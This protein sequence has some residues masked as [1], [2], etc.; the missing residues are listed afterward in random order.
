MQINLYEYIKTK[1]KYNIL[2]YS[3]GGTGKT[4]QMI[5]AFQQI[6][7]S[8]E[9][10]NKIPL[11][12]DVKLLDFNSQTPILKFLSEIYLGKQEH[13]E[14]LDLI[15]SE[16][17]GL[18]DLNGK[19][20]IFFID[21][22]NETT[23]KINIL[24]DINKLKQYPACS[25][26]VSSRVDEDSFVFEDFTR[27]KLKKIKHSNIVRILNEEYNFSKILSADVFDD[28]L[29]E[30]LEYPLFLK[31]FCMAYDK[32]EIM[33][34]INNKKSVRK[35]DIITAY[36]NKI[37][38]DIKR[39]KTV[40]E[41]EQIE[42]STRFFL[43]RLAFLLVG[44]EKFVFTHQELKMLLSD[45]T[46]D[47]ISAKYFMC[48]LNGKESR[49]FIS[50]Y[51][52]NEYDVVEHCLN[53]SLLKYNEHTDSYEFLHHIW[54]DYFASWHIVNLING[55]QFHELLNMP[56]EIMIRSFVGEMYKKNGKCEYDYAK[57][58]T[59]FSEK[60]PIESYMQTHCAELNRYPKV[61]AN[62][63]DIMKISRDNRITAIYDNL[64]LQHVTFVGC[65]L[66]NSSFNNS[67]IYEENFYAQGH[68]GY[69][70]DATIAPGNQKIISCG[71]DSTIR[72]WDTTMQKQIGDPLRGH[73]NY[74]VSVKTIKDGREIISGSYDGT[75]RRWN[76]ETHK[77]I[78]DPLLGHEKRINQIA[79]TAD[80]KYIV[81]CS[82][83][84]TIRIWSLCNG[85]QEGEALYGHNGVVNSIC[86]LPGDRYIISAG[87]DGTVRL[88]D[89][90]THKQSGTSLFGHNCSVKSVCATSDGK[91]VISAD[92]K[93]KV[94]IW[95]VDSRKRLGNALECSMDSVESIAISPDDSNILA[96]GYDGKIR[97]FDIKQR[98]LIGQIDAHGD[99]INGIS[100]SNDGKYI[101][102]AGGDQAV[103]LWDKNTLSLVGK[104]YI[105]TDSWINSV[106]ITSDS[107]FII[108]A[109]DD[110]A[111]RIWDVSRKRM[112]CEPRYGHTARI[113]ELDVS[114]KGIIVSASD[115]G[116]VGVWNIDDES[117]SA[118]LH[119]HTSWVRT[120]LLF[121]NEKFAIS[122]GWDKKIIIWDLT[123]RRI[124]KELTGHNASVEALALTSNDEFLISGSD[125][126]TIRFWNVK[127][128]TESEEPIVAHDDWIR[129][130]KLTGNE[131]AIITGS[132]DNTIRIWDAK[133]H[134]MLGEN[135]KG[136]SNRIDALA[137]SKDNIIISGSDDNTVRAWIKND[138]LYTGKIIAN[139]NNA[140]SSVSIS[141]DSKYVASGDGS[142]IIK[143]TYLDK[144]KRND[145]I[146]Q[147]R[148]NIFN[149]DLTNVSDASVTSKE[150]LH[151]LY[152]NGC[153]I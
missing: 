135:L 60:S 39:R 118:F 62:L 63:I 90:I 82:S 149:S 147:L 34:F 13:Y 102:S 5:Y 87:E 140:V 21:G 136:H 25:L 100:F 4:T 83:D 29:L 146:Q 76:A 77:Q 111:I 10:N 56:S 40:D 42:F 46:P 134:N 68:S 127:N 55:N 65:Q 66:P 106:K 128:G 86:V 28:N 70:Y 152:Q 148:L 80:E 144:E 81:S 67:K 91:Y 94:F 98:T 73:T 7:D 120:V 61:V 71:K 115:D 110:A 59:C 96:A 113:N 141:N 22:L 114:E 104:P 79:I 53:L 131:N 121:G 99:W 84:E 123:N 108:S 33:D 36:I 88:W 151:V 16:K 35:T 58:T 112:V 9:I 12:I 64:D 124:M 1:G 78:G 32:A 109:G 93:G 38:Q 74:V 51:I 14:N 26:I 44:N 37:M 23:N 139:H 24:N 126:E 119:G 54:R 20:Y 50:K 122:G 97:V 95:D 117:E 43:P 143:I 2:L 153:L 48:L 3:E 107:Q 15:I 27:I 150:L 19:E 101:V 47:N 105:G 45:D 138:G 145:T 30:I 133:S 18:Y 69:V 92:Q 129:A 31:V 6:L 75:I 57:K 125:D 72:I 41:N 116:T 103:K 52:G 130:L 89:F 142:G 49:K 137:V 8:R 17:L 85:V 11:Y 132:W